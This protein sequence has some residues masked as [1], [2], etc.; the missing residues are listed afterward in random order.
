MRFLATLQGWQK[1]MHTD[2]PSIRPII[3]KYII[4]WN[5]LHHKQQLCNHLETMSKASDP[6]NPP[7]EAAPEILEGRI[8]VDG[9]WDFF[10]HGQ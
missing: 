3:S 8:W 6:Q 7:G 4:I 9:C 1:P 10:H 2:Y 5:P